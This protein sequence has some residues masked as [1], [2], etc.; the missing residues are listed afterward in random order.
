VDIEA[1]AER[2]DAGDAGELRQ[3]MEKVFIEDEPR[4][5]LNNCLAQIDALVLTERAISVGNVRAS[6]LNDGGEPEAIEQ[7]TLELN[8]INRE[9]SD[10]KERIAGKNN[11]SI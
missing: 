9:L 3:I 7:L 10:V 8:E 11:G 4:R 6:L 1:A 5:Q 2:L